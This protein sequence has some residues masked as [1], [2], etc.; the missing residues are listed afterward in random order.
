ML[1]KAI[2]FGVTGQDGSFLSEHLLDNGWVVVGVSRR[3]SLPNMGRVDH[4]FS[5]P[6][7]SV[8]SGD[9]TD[10]ASISRIINTIFTEDCEAMHVYNLAAQSHVGESFKCPISTWN[11]TGGGTLNILESI[12][13]SS[14]PNLI[15]FYQASSSEMFGNNRRDSEG[16][17]DETTPFSPRS[18]Y[19]VAKTAAHNMTTLYRDAYG[20]YACGGI[21]FNHESERRGDTFVTKKITKYVG[22]LYHARAAGK[23]IPKLKLGNI[24]SSRDWGFAGEYVK[25]MHK[26]LCLGNGEAGDYVIATGKTFTVRDFLKVSFDQI[27]LDYEDYIEIDPDL[28]RPAEVH[29]LLGDASKARRDLGWNPQYDV[30]GLAN[31]M[32]NYEIQKIPQ[33]QDVRTLTNAW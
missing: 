29:R 13:L 20:L 32:V 30:W 31:R 7:F 15:R 8:V 22:E 33:T 12:R 2:I 17:A 6:S 24:D 26:M 25:A 9:I 27:D 16:Y 23:T 1:K 5:H 28:L 19:A 18:P 21:L 10:F 4:L 11:M 14:F 3:T